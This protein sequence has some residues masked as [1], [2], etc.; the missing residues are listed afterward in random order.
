MTVIEQVLSN[1]NYLKLT[2]YNLCSSYIMVTID[3]G[4]IL[5]NELSRLQI[6]TSMKDE[7]M[8]Y[9][10]KFS[11]IFLRTQLEFEYS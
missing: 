9:S 4:C 7:N 5:V 8:L 2:C 10:I 1:K 3:I 11:N 6:C